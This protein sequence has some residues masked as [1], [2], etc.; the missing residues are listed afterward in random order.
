M[1]WDILQAAG[2]DQGKVGGPGVPLQVHGVVQDVHDAH[3]TDQDEEEIG[4]NIMHCTAL[5]WL[6]HGL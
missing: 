5:K 6:S 4:T 3:Q 1:F 2:V